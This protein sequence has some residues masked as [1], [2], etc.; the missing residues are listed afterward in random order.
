MLKVER[1]VLKLSTVSRYLKHWGYDKATNK[2]RVNIN[3]FYTAVLA[4]LSTAKEFKVLIQ[5]EIR[6]QKVQELIR[7]INKPVAFF[8]DSAHYLHSRT[9][10]GLK[11][12]I[13]TIENA[14]GTLTIITVDHPKLGNDLNRPAMKEIGARAKSFSLDSGGQQKQCYIE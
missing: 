4:Y 1:R 14:K 9:L 8:I 3:T 13:E 2:C 6:E 5:A 7:K 10:I 12:L 11:Q